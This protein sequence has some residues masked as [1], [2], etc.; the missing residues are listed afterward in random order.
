VEQ[1]RRD[2]SLYSLPV[3]RGTI[4]RASLDRDL[5]P[6]GTTSN[7]EAS[8]YDNSDS[9]IVPRG[10]PSRPVWFH[11]ANTARL[12]EKHTH[13]GASHS[14]TAIGKQ[15]VRSRGEPEGLVI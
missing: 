1:V 3:P 7:Q 9:P 12:T 2:R 11:L 5:V 14:R 10:T 15:T 4:A 8:D 13:D 6:R